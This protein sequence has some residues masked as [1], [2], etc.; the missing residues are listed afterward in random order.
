MKTD[1]KSLTN[2]I[3]HLSKSNFVTNL[4]EKNEI[5]SNEID[6]FTQRIKSEKARQSSFELVK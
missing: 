6:K 4:N 5:L 3:N 1:I 2:R